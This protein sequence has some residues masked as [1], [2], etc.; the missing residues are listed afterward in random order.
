M[1]GFDPGQESASFQSRQQNDFFESQAGIRFW[2]IPKFC[3]RCLLPF[4]IH[5]KLARNVILPVSADCKIHTH[6]DLQQE[7]PIYRSTNQSFRSLTTT[8]QTFAAKSPL[9]LIKNSK[10]TFSVAVHFYS[11]ISLLCLINKYW[12]DSWS[13]SGPPGNLNHIFAIPI[14]FTCFFMKI[15]RN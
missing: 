1:E 7:R 3:F 6:S 10:K 9:F 5:R 15:S 2:S 13:I 4:K 12:M 11:Y 14:H 8:S